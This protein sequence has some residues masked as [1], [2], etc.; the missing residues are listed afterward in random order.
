M[1]LDGVEIISNSSGSHHELR[2][3]N[4]R[5]NIIRNSTAKC[6]GVYLYAN[7]RGCDG[8]RLYYDGCAA[9]AINGQYL[10]QGGQFGLEEVEVL[11]AVVDIDEVHTYRNSIR[12]LQFQVRKYS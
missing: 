4:K 8:E 10:A 2:K 9:I 3:S 6:G 11:S 1:A 7:Q 12:S 5:I